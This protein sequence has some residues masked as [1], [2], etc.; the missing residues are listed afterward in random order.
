[1]DNLEDNMSRYRPASDFA[2]DDYT[3]EPPESWPEPRKARFRA[4]VAAQP[5]GWW[6]R[7]SEPLLAEYVLALEMAETLQRLL[8]RI[9]AE[10]LDAVA[11]IDEIAR[12]LAARDRE[13][14][15]AIQLARVMR[16]AQQS[17]APTAAARA[18]ERGSAGNAPW[19]E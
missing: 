6:S 1:L 19:L 13:S 2:V 10:G 14:K 15:R 9:D 18:L 3:P 7:A 17:V 16:L 4:I 12:L 5:A 11:N 8:D